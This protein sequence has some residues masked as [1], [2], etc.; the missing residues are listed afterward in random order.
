MRFKGLLA[1]LV[2][3]LV[4]DFGCQVNRPFGLPIATL[5][6]LVLMTYLRVGW[7]EMIFKLSLAGAAVGLGILGGSNNI[8]WMCDLGFNTVMMSMTVA[9]FAWIFDLVQ[10]HHEKVAIPQAH[11]VKVKRRVA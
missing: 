2:G 4:F 5:S 11:A 6:W 1:V 9:M 3:A 7:R 10:A 8:I